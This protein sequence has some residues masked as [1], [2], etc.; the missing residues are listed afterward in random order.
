MENSRKKIMIPIIVIPVILILLILGYSIYFV[1][2]YKNDFQGSISEKKITEYLEN[3]YNDN[4]FANIKLVGK[5]TDSGI[6]G[7][8]C[9]GSQFSTLHNN[10]FIYYYSAHSTK[11]DKDYIVKF[12][13]KIFGADCSCTTNTESLKVVSINDEK[14]DEILKVLKN[15]FNNVETIYEV[16]RVNNLKVSYEVVINDDFDESY[17]QKLIELKKLL[18]GKSSKR[19]GDS[20][21][22]YYRYYIKFN[23]CI[24]EYSPTISSYKPNDFLLGIMGYSS[25][26][27]KEEMKFEISIE[28]EDFWNYVDK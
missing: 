15:R 9:D 21:S 23:N 4:T 16:N 14:Q 6:E 5:A 24:F 13:K 2:Q 27:G 11:D 26:I 10:T 1:N 12:E 7:A 8:S 3:K 28:D 20:S 19:N 22:V 18:Y 25:N 17:Y